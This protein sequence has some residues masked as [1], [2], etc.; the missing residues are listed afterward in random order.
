MQ[1]RYL[2]P[3]ILRNDRCDL[4]HVRLTSGPHPSANALAEKDA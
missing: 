1:L 3:P 4:I 2:L